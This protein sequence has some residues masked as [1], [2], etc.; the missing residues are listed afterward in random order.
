[1]FGSTAVS[2]ARSWERRDRQRNA[3]RV[4]AMIERRKVHVGAGALAT[5]AA[6]AVAAMLPPPGVAR[7]GPSNPC[8]TISPRSLESYGRTIAA[9]H[10]SASADAAKNGSA[11]AYAVAATNSR[12]LLKRAVDRNAAAIAALQSS[13]PAVTTAAEAGTV[14]E[15]VRYILEVVPQAAHWSLISE[16]YHDSPDARKAFEG[17]VKVLEEGNRL[18][19][20]AGRCYMDGL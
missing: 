1:M 12:D 16:I 6:I 11:G 5:L 19:A 8:A 14:K 10:K 7:P 9:A 4:R 3:N 17:S 15:H 18:F 2:H 20:E 13:N